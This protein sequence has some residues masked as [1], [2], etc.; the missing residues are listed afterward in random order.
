MAYVILKLLLQLERKLFLY[1]MQTGRNYQPCSTLHF[2][3]DRVT[4]M[5]RFDTSKYLIT[6][7]TYI[8]NNRHGAIKPCYV[9]QNNNVQ[10]L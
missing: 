8:S 2:S 1:N 10:C 7:D 6:D 4:V 5:Q 9:N 3:T